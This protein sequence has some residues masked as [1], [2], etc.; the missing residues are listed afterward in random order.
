[1]FASTLKA[2]T[3][4]GFA[5]NGYAL[6]LK[7]GAICEQVSADE[8]STQCSLAAGE[9]GGDTGW[10]TSLFISEQLRV[11]VCLPISASTN[12]WKV[13]DTFPWQPH[14]FHEDMY[15]SLQEQTQPDGFVFSSW[16]C[17]GSISGCL[18]AATG[19]FVHCQSNTTLAYFQLGNTSSKGAPSPF[20]NKTSSTFVVPNGNTSL[21]EYNQSPQGPL[22]STAQAMFGNDSWFAQ[23]SSLP[24][25]GL[26]TQNQTW[27]T[28]L[29]LL[30]HT[31][32][33][34]NAGD[35]FEGETTDFCTFADFA[36]I[37]NY[38]PSELLA[39]IVRHFFSFFDQPWTARAALNTG[40]FFAND[41]L[42][43]AALANA[44]GRNTT[45]IVYRYD[46]IETRPVIPVV[47]V[48][49]L[50]VVSLLIGLQ[51][52]AILLLLAYIYS[53]RV[54]TKTL[55]AFAMIRIGAQLARLD[56]AAG[57]SRLGVRSMSGRKLANLWQRD[58]LIDTKIVIAAAEAQS[59]AQDGV[60]LGMLPPPYT[61]RGREAESGE[62]S[63]RERERERGPNGDARPPP[64]AA[65][66]PPY[67]PS[68]DE[69]VESHVHGREAE[70]PREETER[71]RT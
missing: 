29:Q 40:A 64:W 52:I 13:D 51:V 57:P 46:G 1:M 48:P 45:N 30:C 53:T 56:A 47:S 18:G 49:A 2:G 19:L 15:I 63:Q 68:R 43:S 62:A 23:I 3:S 71:A 39:A 31:L 70:S 11:D 21:E 4:T 69:G 27:Y 7:S 35:Y 28:V 42:L 24:E 36:Y 54:W 25:D 41:Y 50:I 14:D 22:M 12:T 37:S 16:G 32:P 55:D 6:G 9:P 34:S 38:S 65:S 58:G 26:G 44:E 10:N 60:E 20:L 33:L 8:V 59:R 66:A 61:A 67:V 17:G 5:A